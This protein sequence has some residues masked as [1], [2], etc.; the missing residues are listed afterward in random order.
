MIKNIIIAGLRKFGYG[1]FKLDKSE[2]SNYPDIN[3][4]DFWQTYK[5][6]KPYTMTSVERMFALYQS[7]NYVLDNSIPG[8][9][10]ECGVWRGGSSMMVAFILKKRNVTDRKIFLYDTYEGMPAPTENDKDL[11]GKNAGSLMEETEFMKQDSVI[12]CIADL[13]DVKANIELT[14]I[15]Q[16]QI[17]FVKGK[18]ED[19]IPNLI[20]DGG[21]CLLR[22]DTDWYE[23]TKHEL[24]HLFP[25]LSK[26]GILII[27]DYG[28]WEGCRKAVDEYFNSISFKP[29]IQ[30]IDYSGRLIT[31]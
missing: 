10:V 6:C 16:N 17:V 25:K 15:S 29:L 30:R 22:L 19:T 4:I 5:M 3:Q 20:P 21:I 24:I 27:D 23:S 28:H 8:D 11:T 14:K 9:F 31:N 2:P 13:N 7:V 26:K 12:W 1:L 18:V